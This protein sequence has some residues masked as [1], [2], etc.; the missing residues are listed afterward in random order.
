MTVRAWFTISAIAVVALFAAAA[1]KLTAPTPPPSIVARVG[2][3]RLD[4][5][6]T[7]S[8]WPQSGGKS[9]C[10]DGPDRATKTVT[11]PRRGTIRVVV[12]YPTQ[13]KN[14]SIDLFGSNRP[15]FKKKWMRNVSYDLEPGRYY[16]Q[17]LALYSNS[18]KVQYRFRLRVR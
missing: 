2:S 13:P 12:A 14:G 18:A 9:K 1:L 16:L 5:F 4:G 10:A 6:L 11:I 17:A 15:V 3:I 7:A 8:C